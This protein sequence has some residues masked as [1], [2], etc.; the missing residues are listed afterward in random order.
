MIEKFRGDTFI[1]SFEFKDSNFFDLGDTVRF[2]IK[3]TLCQTDYEAYA[4]KEV[5]ET[6]KS[7]EIQIE[8]ELTEKLVPGIYFMELELIKNGVVSTIYQD[9]FFVNGDVVNERQNPN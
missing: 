5:D 1:F 2:G 9:N 7:I 6:A 3:K 4:E 8:S